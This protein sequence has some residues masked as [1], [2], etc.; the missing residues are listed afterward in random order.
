MDEECRG[1]ENITIRHLLTMSSG[2][3][4]PEFGEW[5]CF[6]PMN[7]SKDIVDFILRRPM[8][9]LP[10]KSM[11]YSSGDT[12]LL[13]EIIANVTNMSLEEF[14]DQELFK[15]LNI[16]EHSWIS[17]DGHALAADGLRLKVSDL[18]KLAELYLGEGTWQ[19]KRILT[20]EW[21]KESMVPRYLTYDNLGNY[22]YQWWSREIDINNHVYRAFFALGY[23]GQF[24]V[25]IPDMRLSAAIVSDI[26]DSMKPFWMLVDAVNELM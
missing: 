1:K 5:N 12:H 17:R 26:D 6:A 16:R 21:V 4:W 19:G 14:A 7:Y 15:P 13:G 8:I 22:G 10:G 3:D 11:N 18:L 23:K 24:S 2:I 20:K 25:L 9:H